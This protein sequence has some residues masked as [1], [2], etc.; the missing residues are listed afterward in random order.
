MLNNA[1]AIAQMTRHKMADLVGKAVASNEM[2][3]AQKG[4]QP[5]L[6]FHKLNREFEGEHH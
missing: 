5:V 2:F 4:L 3:L 1:R 6:I